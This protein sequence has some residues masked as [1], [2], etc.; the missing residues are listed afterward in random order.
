MS[1]SEAAGDMGESRNPLSKQKSE[2]HGFFET[3]NEVGVF[4]GIMEG[5]QQKVRVKVFLQVV[6]L[7]E[8]RE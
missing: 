7:A 6:T 3:N 1:Y 4:P 8:I 5:C 2:H